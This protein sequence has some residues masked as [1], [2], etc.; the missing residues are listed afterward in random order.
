MENQPRD[1]QDAASKPFPIRGYVIINA[2]VWFFSVTQL[3]AVR[4]LIGET[5]GLV[6]FSLA[7]PVGFGVVSVLDAIC[8][9]SGDEVQ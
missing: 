3:L 7:L 5:T 6:F 1:E 8:D 2:A 4:W 9:R